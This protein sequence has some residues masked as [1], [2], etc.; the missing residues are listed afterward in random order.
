[1]STRAQERAQS[2]NT[3]APTSGGFGLF[4]RGRLRHSAHVAGRK[5]TVGGYRK[6]SIY[7]RVVRAVDG[8]LS[9]GSVVA[10]VEVLVAMGL[11][12][13]ERLAD[14]RHGRVPYLERVITCNL[15]RLGRVLRILRF[16]AHD[17]NL[18]PS[19]TA[20]MRKAQGPK[21]RLRFT[22]TGEPNL[23][24]AYATHFVW[25]GKEPCCARSVTSETAAATCLGSSEDRESAR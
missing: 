6:D 8:L 11:L 5:N 4:A 1:M 19:W 16:H 3:A 9:R 14:W 7:P 23:E 21:Q 22:K 12:T 24:A 2:K 15:A 18:K 13:Q 20:Y 17:Q 10:P 25:L